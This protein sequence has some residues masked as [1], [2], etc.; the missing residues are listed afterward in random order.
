MPRS[1][2]NVNPVVYGKSDNRLITLSDED[3][4]VHDEIDRREVFD[5]IRGIKGKYSEADFKTGWLSP[6]ERSVYLQIRNIP[7]RWRN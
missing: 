5:L 7:L 6:Y 1:L 2:E 3:E 4:D